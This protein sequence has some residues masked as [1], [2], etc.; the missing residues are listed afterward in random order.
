M[1]ENPQ[2]PPRWGSAA[3]IA[4]VKVYLETLV[5]H[6]PYDPKRPHL[7]S[8]MDFWL[9]LFG[10]ELYSLDAELQSALHHIYTEYGFPPSLSAKSRS[11]SPDQDYNDYKPD[12]MDPD[13][14]YDME[15]GGKRRG[16]NWEEEEE[17]E[18]DR[19][20]HDA[21][22]AL[23]AETQRGALEIAARIDGVLENA[24]Y[25]TDP[26]LLRLRGHVSL[27]VA[28]LYLPSRLASQYTK[29]AAMAQG[30]ST[31]S[32]SPDRQLRT[33]VK[34]PEEH[35]ALSR[36]REEQERARAFFERVLAAKGK[37]EDWILR[38]LDADEGEET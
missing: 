19:H 25:T 37:L 29:Q 4:Q 28:D 8:A 27:C 18:D 16:S 17:E 3:N 24:P 15:T 34:T 11:P 9:A 32:E 38:F 14:D 35:V 30:A 2:P 1:K 10:I 22:D 36:R 6:H 31:I 20:R 7:T 33:H 12:R 21:I 26:E 5:Q 13:D 23:L